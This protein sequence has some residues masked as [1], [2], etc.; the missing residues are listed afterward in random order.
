LL[1]A[2]L[3]DSAVPGAETE[4]SADATDFASRSRLDR[5]WLGGIWDYITGED[6]IPG[7]YG[8]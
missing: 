7:Y 1:A 6:A 8:Q 4:L 2:D 3:S 5:G